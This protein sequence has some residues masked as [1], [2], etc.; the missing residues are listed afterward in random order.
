MTDVRRDPMVD[1]LIW[2]SEGR[3]LDESRRRSLLE[4]GPA[5]VN[6]A[7]LGFAVVDRARTPEP[8]RAFA[9][10]AFG[11]ELIDVS[12]ELELYRPTAAALR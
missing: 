7:R 10:D 9:I 6:R 11:L 2:L 5:F 12:G 3:P 8:L 1:A 4:D